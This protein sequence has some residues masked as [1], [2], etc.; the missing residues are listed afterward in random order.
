MIAVNEARVEGDMSDEVMIKCFASV[1]S[2]ST[3]ISFQN[4][5]Q[6]FHSIYAIAKIFPLE[7]IDGNLESLE[8]GLD[9]L[10]NLKYSALRT[11]KFSKIAYL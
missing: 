9:E 6:V 10:Q 2:F 11:L 5:D 4:I 3:R 8:M 7:N 1:L